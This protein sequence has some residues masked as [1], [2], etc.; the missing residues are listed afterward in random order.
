MLIVECFNSMFLTFFPSFDMAP[1]PK[2]HFCCWH[3]QAELQYYQYHQ[4]NNL[5]D[6]K[7]T[8]TWWSHLKACLNASSF[9]RDAR[10]QT[11]FLCTGDHT[12]S[13]ELAACADSP[14][15]WGSSCLRRTI[16]R[17]SQI[18]GGKQLD[19]PAWK[20]CSWMIAQPTSTGCSVYSLTLILK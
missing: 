4:L 8:Q 20:Q 2:H 10:T 17:L 1:Q 3:W 15:S 13:D 5:T 18:L 9:P 6:H 16:Q 7:E 19:E 14:F 11:H 12:S